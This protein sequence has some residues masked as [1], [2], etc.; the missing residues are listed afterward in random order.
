[1]TMTSIQTRPLVTSS[2]GTGTQSITSIAT[3]VPPATDAEGLSTGAKAGIGVG[4]AGALLLF[5]ATVLLFLLFR[6]RRKESD[7]NQD[8]NPV[9]QYGPDATQ[10]ANH[11][12]PSSYQPSETTQW[13]PGPWAPQELAA[14]VGN[15]FKSELPANER[16]VTCE[17]AADHPAIPQGHQGTQIGSYAPA[18]APNSPYST[19]DSSGTD[20]I[21]SYSGAPTMW[22][23]SRYIVTPEPK[24][25]TASSQS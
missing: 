9:M 16:P 7:S 14:Q 18:I 23:G 25:H 5:V 1:M 2:T 11:T 13:S 20:Q 15:D 17:L 6:R 3:S 4:A 19:L 24:S 21:S 10:N 12:Y 22:D 8:G